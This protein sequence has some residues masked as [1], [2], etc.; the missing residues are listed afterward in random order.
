M[1]QLA[2]QVAARLELKPGSVVFDRDQ[3]CSEGL[4]EDLV[5]DGDTLVVFPRK[6]PVEPA[7]SEPNHVGFAAPAAEAD[8]ETVEL[9]EESNHPNSDENN[10]PQTQSDPQFPELYDPRAVLPEMDTPYLGPNP[11]WGETSV[12]VESDQ[13]SNTTNWNPPVAAPIN[14]W[15]SQQYPQQQQFPQQYPQQQYPVVHQQITPFVNN[16]HGWGPGNSA[17]YQNGTV[18][19]QPLASQFVYQQPVPATQGIGYIL[20]VDPLT[21]GQILETGFCTAPASMILDLQHHIQPGTRLFL[22]EY[23]T[24]RIMGPLYASSRP[25]IIGMI[26]GRFSAHVRFQYANW[27]ASCRHRNKLHIGAV[28]S[29]HAFDLEQQLWMSQRTIANHQQVRS[30]INGQVSSHINDST[31]YRSDMKYSVSIEEHLWSAVSNSTEIKRLS[32]RLRTNGH[33]VHVRPVQES[34]TFDLKSCNESSLEL[35]V[36]IIRSVEHK[37]SCCF[38]TDCPPLSASQADSFHAQEQSLEEVPPH[39]EL[40]FDPEQSR[41][42]VLPHLE[43]Q[44]VPSDDDETASESSNDADDY[45]RDQ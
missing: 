37:I 4:V 7:V 39:L 31:S 18:Y 2:N 23:K 11:G 1:E 9:H 34:F 12:I 24:K 36:Q 17:I 29:E 10:I 33:S 14:S 44:D 30:Q 38:L 32:A 13:W 19:Q 43:S 41:E 16:Q 8:S 35:A 45:R 20:H 22:W 25:M 42:K 6:H 3:I 26:N 5:G 27:F 21:R 40:M 28:T 15:Q